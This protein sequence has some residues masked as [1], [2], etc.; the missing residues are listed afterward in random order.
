MLSL[1]SCVTLDKSFSIA[2]CLSFLSIYEDSNSVDL[3]E[4]SRGLNE[5]IPVKCL[6]HAVC[7]INL[8]TVLS[9]DL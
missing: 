5:L 4:S 1:P 8:A 6:A 9:L 7:L 2:L 3:T